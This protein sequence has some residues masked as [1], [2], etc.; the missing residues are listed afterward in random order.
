MKVFF[1]Y[2]FLVM[3]TLNLAIPL[4]EQLR[5][6]DICALTEVVSEDADEEGKT[7]KEKEKE[8]ISFSGDQVDHMDAYNLEKFKKSL[9]PR[10][11]FPISELFASL[12]ELPPEV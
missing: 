4:V 10:Y 12:P 3:M 2:F 11:D 5:G 6:E 1:S 8:S 7:E 9:F